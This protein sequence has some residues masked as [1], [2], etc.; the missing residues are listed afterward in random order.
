MQKSSSVAMDESIDIV[1]TRVLA[2]FI[3]GG[4]QAAL[5]SMKGSVTGADLYK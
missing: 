5:L 3:R 1:I 4:E 2:I